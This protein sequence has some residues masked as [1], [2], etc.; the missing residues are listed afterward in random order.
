MISINEQNQASYTTRKGYL[1]K[2]TNWFLGL[3]FADLI[4]DAIMF[5]RQKKVISKKNYLNLFR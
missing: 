3:Y 4:N 1:C 5:N 2:H